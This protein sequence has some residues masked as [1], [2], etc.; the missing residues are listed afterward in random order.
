MAEEPGGA[1]HI[2][3]PFRVGDWF[4][5]PSA[6]RI[7]HNREERRLEPKVMALLV[8]FAQTPGRTRM[9]E[10][11]EDKL[12]PG[13]T[14]GY[15]ALASAVSKLR[16][17]LGD[18]PSSPSFVETIPKVGYRMVAPVTPAGVMSPAAGSSGNR[19]PW[20][21]VTALF[22]VAVL[23]AWLGLASGLMTFLLGAERVTVKPSIAVLPLVNYTNDPAQTVWSDALAA[24]IIADLSHFS[25]FFV[26]ASN[27]SFSYRDRTEDIRQVGQDLGV[28]YV[29]EG[30]FWRSEAGFRVTARL[31]E[32]DS[33]THVWAK[34][35]SAPASGLHTLP[36]E[37]TQEIVS[38]L[39]G[40][41][42][43]REL[44]RISDSDISS[45]EAYELVQMGRV[46]WL[47]WTAGANAKA[48]QLYN[49]AIELDPDYASAYRSLA[50]VHINEHRYGWNRPRDSALASAHVAVAR[51]IELAPFDYRVLWTR[52]TVRMRSG[53]LESALADFRRALELNPNAADVMADMAVPLVYAGEAQEAVTQVQQAIRRNPLHPY[54]YDWN[55]AWAYYFAGDPDA[56]LTAFERMSY[57]PERALLTRA[58]IYQR[59]GRSSEAQ[60]DAA[61]FLKATPSHT[62]EDEAEALSP[63]RD[64]AMQSLWLDD[65]RAAGIPE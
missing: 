47:K 30:G 7:S 34:K 41:I 13:V 37:V 19:K 44:E 62:L 43:A 38:T 23:A 65:L 3:D 10:E 29:I 53:D 60:A 12:W 16:S 36:A 24:E 32:T 17:A 63:L 42:D 2:A 39:G 35:F 31:I 27:S 64:A 51:A 20:L 57:V 59:L 61:N 9:R 33:G 58:A 15:D 25:D 46:E 48:E 5:E 11:L 18:D 54:W 50:W 55:L 56:G 45:P 52:A 4:V 26:V 40:R 1:E 6:L 21:W 8:F 49:R 14:V 22:S 28:R